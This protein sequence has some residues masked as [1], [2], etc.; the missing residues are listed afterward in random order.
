M[1]CFYEGGRFCEI[2]DD[3]G[4]LGVAVVHGRKGG[5][6]FLACGIPYLEFDGAVWEVGF[7]G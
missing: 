6:A 7:L 3:E 2:V 4:G 1:L 5:E